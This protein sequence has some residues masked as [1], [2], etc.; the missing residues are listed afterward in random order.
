[1]AGPLYASALAEV[2]TTA[3]VGLAVRGPSATNCSAAGG[4]LH[5]S[6]GTF[7]IAPGRSANVVVGTKRTRLQSLLG[8]FA[9]S[10]RLK[11]FGHGQQP[12]SST[13]GEPLQHDQAPRLNR[14][15]ATSTRGVRACIRRVAGCATPT[16]S[17]GHAGA[18][19]NLKLTF[20]LD[21]RSA[22]TDLLSKPIHLDDIGNVWNSWLLGLYG[23]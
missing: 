9:R 11:N 4:A 23:E 22:G 5:D 1:M 13:A 12:S 15:Q 10:I 21:H 20:H 14:I 16:G 6:S 17:A 7:A 2:G 18:T 3:C 8:R 19:A